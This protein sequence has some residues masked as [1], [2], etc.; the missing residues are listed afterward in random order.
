VLTN[1]ESSIASTDPDLMR[2]YGDM[3]RILNSAIAS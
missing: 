3:C 2:A 1:I